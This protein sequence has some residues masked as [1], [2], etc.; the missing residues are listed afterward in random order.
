MAVQ[1]LF[2]V[3][4]PDSTSHYMTYGQALALQEALDNAKC[5]YSHEIVEKP[6]SLHELLQTQPPEYFLAGG[7]SEA[8]GTNDVLPR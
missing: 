5:P 6:P 7:S 3:Q 1:R 4:C 2:R 8:G